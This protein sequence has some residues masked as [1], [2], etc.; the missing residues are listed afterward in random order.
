MTKPQKPTDAP[1]D[2]EPPEETPAPVGE[3]QE[4]SQGQD[5]D[6]KPPSRREARFRSELRA[7]EATIADLTETI[8]TMR[9]GEAERQATSTGDV[10]LHDGADLWRDGATTADLLDENGAISPDALIAMIQSVTAER[11]HLVAP[12]PRQGPRPDFTQGINSQR[13]EDSGPMNWATAMRPK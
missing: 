12:E 5:D 2:Q 13:T 7:A 6:G 10:R 8:E 4:A 1:E 9:R 3:P 11:P